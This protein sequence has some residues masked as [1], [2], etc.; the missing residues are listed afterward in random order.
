MDP[1]C[2][3]AVSGGVGGAKLARGFAGILPAG[4]LGVLTNVGDDCRHLGLHIAPDLDTVMYTLGGVANPVLGWGRQD[5]SWAFM[6]ALAALGGPTWFKLG[7]RD[8]ATHMRRT[9]LLEQG[10]SL[11]QAT[12]MLCR[13]FGIASEIIPATDDALRTIVDTDAGVLAFQH[14]FVREA[15]RPVV[16]RLRFDGA[17]RAVPSPRAVAWCERPD[18]TAIVLCPSNPYLS[19]D[20]ILAIPGLRERLRG[21][22]R[23]ARVPVVAVSPLIGGAAVKGPTAKI[24]QELGIDQSVVSIARH[25]HGLIDGLLLDPVDGDQAAAVEAM[26]IAT[27]TTGILMRDDADKER[28]ARETLAFARDL[29]RPLAR[30][31]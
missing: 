17:A 13:G 11:T 5:E 29:A 15:C 26:G 30:R 27:L 25:Y 2:V 16:R 22:G 19:I 20:P 8:L 24:M 6:D 21:A 23:A 7:V 4:Q 1:A 10:L 3:L 18:L 12:A 14:Y 31:S 28:L 9:E